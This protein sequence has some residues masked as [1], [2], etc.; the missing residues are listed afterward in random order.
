MKIRPVEVEL[1]R[2]DR[3]GQTGTIKPTVIFRNCFKNQP[4]SV[5][6]KCPECCKFQAS[7]R[8]SQSGGSK[9]ELNTNSMAIS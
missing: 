4:Y 3:R 6:L 8:E 9:V 7:F 2:T 5:P 1:F